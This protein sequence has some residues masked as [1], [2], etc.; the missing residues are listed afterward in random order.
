MEGNRYFW[1]I[2]SRPGAKL[3]RWIINTSLLE[4]RSFLQPLDNLVL[5]IYALCE[6]LGRNKKGVE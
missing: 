3:S 4:D 1:K 6:I 2:Y 5:I